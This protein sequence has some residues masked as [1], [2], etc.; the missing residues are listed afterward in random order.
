MIK[1]L[2]LFF[3][4]LNVATLS[5]AICDS[6]V[7]GNCQTDID[8]IEFQ[9]IDAPADSDLGKA[10]M[11]FDVS[12]GKMKCSEDGGVYQNCVGGLGG[13]GG[14]G[15][16]VTVQDAGVN[17]VTAANTFNFTSPVTITVGSTP[18]TANIAFD[19]ATTSAKGIA[20]FATTYFSVSSGQVSIKEDGIIKLNIADQDH[21]D[22][23]YSGNNASLDTGVVDANELVS[24]A[25]TPGSYT[26]ADITVDADGR[27]TAA[28]NGSSGGGGGSLVVQEADVN[29]VSSAGTIDF[30]AGFDVSASPSGEANIVLDYTEDPVD[31]STSEVTGN[32]PD[33]NIPNNITIDLAATATALAANG[34]N[35]SA[36][37][38]PLGVN[39][40]GAVESCTADDD[41]PEA[42]DFGNATDLDANGA[43]V[44][45]GVALATDTTGNYVADITAGRSLTASG[46]GSENATVTIDADAELY[47]WEKDFLIINGLESWDNYFHI[48]ID[49]PITITEI[50]CSTD[51]STMSI[52]F[53]HRLQTT[54]N[55][56][57]TAVNQTAIVCDTNQETT[58]IFNDAT[59]PAGRL[60]SLSDISTTSTTPGV[61]RVIVR[62]T[63]DD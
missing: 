13:G 4:L 32:L 63:R 36:G 7:D 49:S 20:S 22:F 8:L 47:A 15:A 61:T 26:N 44:A 43:V 33:G 60:I 19:D 6:L 50:S 57:G 3:L 16:G 45:N 11:Y 38:Y 54:P 35:C 55:T 29:V 9:A 28:S 25:V 30:G 48:D 27:I 2:F 59:I 39:A 23:T 17:R 56:A 10:R 46:G 1:K 21:G 53:D 51:T 40:S 34:A 24:T 37:N 41:V 14:S 58:T 12:E 18:R 31:L 5:H 62:G 42:G 52:T